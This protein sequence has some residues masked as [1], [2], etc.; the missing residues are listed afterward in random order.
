MGANG[1]AYFRFE[2]LCDKPLGAADYFGLFSKSK[3]SMELVHGGFMV[4]LVMLFRIR[5]NIL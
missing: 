5:N 2:E 3:T 4:N 1:C